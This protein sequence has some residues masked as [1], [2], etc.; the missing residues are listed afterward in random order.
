M[1]NSRISNMFQERQMGG[2]AAGF[3]GRLSRKFTRRGEDRFGR[4]IYHQ[5]DGM[6]KNLR[7]Y[8]L[9]RVYPKPNKSRH[10][11]AWDQQFFC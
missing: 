11:T 4:W 9:Y 8:T 5:F 10:T 1:T 3:Y 7:V 2:V 6:H